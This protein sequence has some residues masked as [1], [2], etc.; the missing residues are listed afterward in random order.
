LRDAF[1]SDAARVMGVSKH[2]VSI[3][4]AE[5]GSLIIKYQIVDPPCEDSEITQRVEE[6]DF[7]EVMALY[8]RRMRGGDEGAA[9]KSPAVPEEEKEVTTT[10]QDCGFEG[11]DWDYVWSIKQEAMCEAFAKGVAD[12]LRIRPADVQ[13][14]NM[15][16]S[17]DGIV[18]G[19]SVTHPLVQDYQTIQKAL[20]DHP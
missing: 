15:E 5:I 14:I 17:D 3:I 13:N 8:R 9:A 1:C 2:N 7:P 20:K 16:K 11:T 10:L 4:S 19:A 6:D 12:A 18:L